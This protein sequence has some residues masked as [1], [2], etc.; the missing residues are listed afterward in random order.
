MKLRFPLFFAI[1]L[2]SLS[3]IAAQGEIKWTLNMNTDQIL[4]TDKR[5]FNALE[6][7][8]I[9]FLN[10]Q[11]WTNDRFEEDERIEATMFFTVSEVFEKSG[12]GDGAS[13][14]V[15]NAYRA[16]VAIQ[17]LRP[18]YNSAEKTPVL[19]TLDKFVE[20]S[21]RQG[22]GVQYSE[23]SYLSDLGAVF[24]FYSYIIIG[25]DYDT[26]SPL[27]GDPYFTKAQELYNRLPNSITND[28]N[29]GWSNA[30][31]KR[32]RYWLME[33]ILQPRMLPLRRAYYTYHRMGLDIMSEDVIAGRNNVTLAIEDLQKA[34]QA[35]PQTMYAQAFVDAKRD[36]IVEIYKAAT[37]IEQNTVIQA[38]TRVDPSK[39]SSYRS[40]R[41]STGSNRRPS[42]G[43]RAPVSR[44]KRGK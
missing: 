42:V 10:S 31:K 6:K 27:G 15:P 43:S 9:T 19:N 26:F 7:D 23:Q 13:V 29:N 36:E 37:G 3:T 8:I 21:Y 24:A 35:Y 5:I 39:S 30:A 25:L 44:G 33:N 40:I 22:E 28:V 1:V 11:N 14:A 17:S 34:N 12:K 4:Q 41:Y 32:N 18:I 38:M 2:F 16:T 20:F